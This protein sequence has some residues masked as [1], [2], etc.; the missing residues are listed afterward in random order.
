MKYLFVIVF[1]A[2]IVEVVTI[3]A[4]I[5]VNKEVVQDLVDKTDLSDYNERF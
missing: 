5:S 4:C 2:L 1:V 3:H